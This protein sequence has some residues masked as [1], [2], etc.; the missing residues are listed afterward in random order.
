MAGKELGEAGFKEE[1]FADGDL[2]RICVLRTDGAREGQDAKKYE[3]MKV[4]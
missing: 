2:R 3:A 1:P 4:H